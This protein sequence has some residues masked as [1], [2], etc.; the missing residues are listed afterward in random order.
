[1]KDAVGLITQIKTLAM[2]DGPGIRTTIFFKGCP[3]SCIWCSNPETQQKY[4]EIYFISNRCRHCGEC[5]KAC[6]E[7]AILQ[8]DNQR[9]DRQKCNRC[10]RCIEVCPG[11]ALE[12]VG[13]EVTAKEVAKKM[14]EDVPFFKRSGGGVTLSGGEPL[15]QPEFSFEL[16]RLLHE[17]GIHTCLDTS[18]YGS[19]ELVKEVIEYVDLILLDIKHMNPEVHRKWTG[20]SNEL[21]LKNA[22]IMA[23]KRKVR[24]SLP[25]IP[26]VNDD[27]ENIEETIKFS[28]ALGIQSIDI[29]LFHRLGTSKYQFLGLKSRYDQ[30][31]TT[32]DGQVDRIT[33]MIK[34]SSLDASNER[35]F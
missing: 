29:M 31:G 35:S 3:L 33:K 19:S 9:I 30:F 8:D 25:L 10:M 13:I 18:G 28:K 22:Q 12:R 4:P 20:V 26:G 23:A 34:S 27:I 7:N 24:I 15:L 1:M 2:H 16:V 5:S 11:N 6:S 21:I 17:K 32:S 14:E